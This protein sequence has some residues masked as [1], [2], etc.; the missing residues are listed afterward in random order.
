MTLT[1]E[2]SQMRRHQYN[3][4]ERPERCMICRAFVATAGSQL[5]LP[6]RDRAVLTATIASPFSGSCRNFSGME[7]A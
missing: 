4:E 5:E 1:G 3:Y 6:R 7:L 2:L